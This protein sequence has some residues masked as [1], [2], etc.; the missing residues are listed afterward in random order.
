MSPSDGVGSGTS[1]T[2]RSPDPWKTSARIVTSS[3]GE[4]DLQRLASAEELEARDISCGPSAKRSLDIRGSCDAS[5]AG[6]YTDL[7]T[8]EL[9]A[10][11]ILCGASAKRSLEL[12]GACDASWASKYADDLSAEELAARLQADDGDTEKKDR[13]VQAIKRNDVLQNE[14]QYRF[15]RSSNLK[16]RK[17]G[18][19]PATTES[20]DEWRSLL[21]GRGNTRANLAVGLQNQ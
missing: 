1:S 18:T 3:G 21:E 15:F 6:K 16:D 10:R 2:R 12:R 17:P 14:L 20:P 19:F 11:D 13:L 4:D 7:S 8:E 9:E 5:W